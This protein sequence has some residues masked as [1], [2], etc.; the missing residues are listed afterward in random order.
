[1]CKYLLQREDNHMYRSLTQYTNSTFT[2]ETYTWFVFICHVLSVLLYV[3]RVYA[4]G[5]IT[6]LAPPYMQST[7]GSR[8]KRVRV[9][10][11]AACCNYF[12]KK[13][14]KKVGL[15]FRTKFASKYFWSYIFQLILW[16]IIKLSMCIILKGRKS[17][18]IKITH[19]W[20]LQL[21]HSRLD[22]DNSKYVW[23]QTFYTFLCLLYIYQI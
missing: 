12:S 19:E 6:E 7:W 8:V 4:K 15:F 3:I 18:V 17:H 14:K 23:S 2:A 11:L 5:F 1:M 20:F 16:K 13:K 9:T 22:Q 10:G 21:L